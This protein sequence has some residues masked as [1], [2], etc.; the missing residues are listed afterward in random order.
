[1]RN[2]VNDK[3]SI[4]ISNPT[5]HTPTNGSRSRRI[6][7]AMRYF[8]K[9]AY[10]TKDNQEIDFKIFAYFTIYMLSYLF[11]ERVEQTITLDQSSSNHSDTLKIKRAHGI[12]QTREY[13]TGSRQLWIYSCNPDLRTTVSVSVERYN[14]DRTSRSG[15]SFCTCFR[16][17]SEDRTDKS[18]IF[19]TK[20]AV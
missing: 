16:P 2:H 12:S 7:R 6:K 5:H 17:S 4:Y 19:A 10:I 9:T 13:Q 14:Q 20:S 8:Q 3:Y 1:M 18:L 15:N 11:F